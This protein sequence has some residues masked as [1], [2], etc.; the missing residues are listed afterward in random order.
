MRVITLLIS[1]DS[2]L[3]YFH[4]KHHKAP[5]VCQSRQEQEVPTMIPALASQITHPEAAPKTTTKLISFTEF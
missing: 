2:F 3:P 4:A 1:T 5:E